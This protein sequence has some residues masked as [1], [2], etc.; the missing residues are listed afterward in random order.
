MGY[1]HELDSHQIPAKC[2][3]ESVSHG[4]GQA[5]LMNCELVPMAMVSSGRAGTEL[6]TLQGAQTSA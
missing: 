5:A 6:R 1:Q 2:T 4:P 3:Y